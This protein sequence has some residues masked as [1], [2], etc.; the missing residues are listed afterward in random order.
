LILVDNVPMDINRINPQDI[1]S[2][3]VLK[4]GA[5]SAIYGARAAFGVVLV[6]TKKENKVLM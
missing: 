2:I 6:E 4:D 3:I 1:E 5:A